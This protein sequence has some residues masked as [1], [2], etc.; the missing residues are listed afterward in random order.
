M[1]FVPLTPHEVAEWRACT[2]DMVADYM[3][4]ND[5]AEVIPVRARCNNAPGPHAIVRDDRELRFAVIAQPVEEAYERRQALV[6]R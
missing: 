2:A 1:K 6:E 5:A 4:K 3:D